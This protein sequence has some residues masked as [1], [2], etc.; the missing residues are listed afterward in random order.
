MEEAQRLGVGFFLQGGVGPE[1]WD[2]QEALV[3]LYP[4][5]L[6]LCFGLHPYW[7]AAHDEDECEQA[8]DLLAQR[9]HRAMALGEA[10]LDFRPHIM[11]ESRERQLDIFAA[12][13]E[14]AE[15]TQKPLVLHLVQAHEEAL[16]ALDMWGVPP[17]GGFVHSFNSSAAKARDF[18]NRGLYLSIGGPVSRRENEKLHQAVRECPLERLLLETDSPDQPPPEYQGTLNPPSSLWSVAKSVAALKGMS[19]TE[20]LEIASANFRRLFQG[21]EGASKSK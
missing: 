6:G 9:L 12:Q 8:L 7:V 16:R 15:A 1:D 5:R 10:G 17:A 18:L 2:R 20:V 19:P 3:K 14:L 21:D 11:K 4:G 13:I